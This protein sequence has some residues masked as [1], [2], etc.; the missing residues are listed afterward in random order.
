MGVA[1][2]DCERIFENFYRGKNGPTLAVRGTGLGLAVARQLVEA[3][4]GTIGVRSAVGYGS[5]FW[6]RLAVPITQLSADEPRSLEPDPP[7]AL[8]A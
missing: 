3:H 4:G 5:T 1:A 7:L 8:S 2:E 6:V